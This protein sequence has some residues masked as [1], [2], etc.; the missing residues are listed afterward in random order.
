MSEMFRMHSHIELDM[1]LRILP[2]S[3]ANTVCLEALVQLAHVRH[4]RALIVRVRLHKNSRVS[5]RSKGRTGHGKLACDISA[6]SKS[7]LSPSWLSAVPVHEGSASAIDDSRPEAVVLFGP[8]ASSR[9]C[10]RHLW[11][12]AGTRAV[13]QSSSWWLSRIAHC[14]GKKS[15]AC[16]SRLRRSNEAYECEAVAERQ[17]KGGDGHGAAL[18]AATRPLQQRRLLR[19]SSRRH[20][21]Q[22]IR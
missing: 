21:A 11:L 8:K 16:S 6:A 17:R 9:F 13:A 10:W 19:L 7:G 3:P 1:P 5:Q 4:H 18:A 12:L 14:N 20:P 2:T 22:Q 15:A